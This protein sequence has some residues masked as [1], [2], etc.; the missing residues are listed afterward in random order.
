[1]FSHFICTDVVPDGCGE[2]ASTGAGH[3]RCADVMEVR[4]TVVCHDVALVWPVTRAFRV[5]ADQASGKPMSKSAKK[6]AARKAKKAAESNDTQQQQSTMQSNGVGT[7]SSRTAQPA[8]AQHTQQGA[9]CQG[10]VDDAG[11]K[12]AR[13]LKKKIRQI[14]E[15]Q[16][17]H[18]AGV[19]LTPEQQQ[20][21]DS[22][23]DLC[24]VPCLRCCSSKA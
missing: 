11:E 16:D 3:K 20:K 9:Q 5:C 12:R 24:A 15:L 18:S 10:S 7:A 19:K 1:M 14:S 22:L 13:A 23:S 17:K 4:Q 2:G 8:S 21:L 6:N